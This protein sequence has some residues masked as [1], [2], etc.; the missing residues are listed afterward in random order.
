[1]QEDGGLVLSLEY[2]A[3]PRVSVSSSQ[4]KEQSEASLKIHV[5]MSGSEKV[6]VIDSMIASFINLYRT[7]APLVPKG[8]AATLRLQFS[9]PC[10]FYTLS[11]SPVL[12]EEGTHASDSWIS[13]FLSS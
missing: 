2:P 9:S 4:Q 13:R 12:L 1:M 8:V 3:A 10:G 5:L 11:H 7:L 6:N